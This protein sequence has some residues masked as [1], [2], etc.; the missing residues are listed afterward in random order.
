M[1]DYKGP[2]LEAATTHFD[3][4]H[5]IEDP[6]TRSLMESTYSFFNAAKRYKNIGAIHKRGIMLYGPPGTGKSSILNIV[7]AKI[8]ES[9]GIVLFAKQNH[10]RSVETLIHQIRNSQ[11][12]LWIGVV[13]E[14]IETYMSNNLNLKMMLSLLSGESQVG[15]VIYMATTN[16][17]IS[18]LPEAITKRP[19]RFDVVLKVDFPS[20]ES[21]L[22]FL[23]K[24]VKGNLSETVCK[25]IAE[26]T[27]GLS[28]AHLKEIVVSHYCLQEDLQ[29][30]I[31]RVSSMRVTAEPVLEDHD[32]DSLESE[33]E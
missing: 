9:G 21:K 4:V 23:T 14:D 17:D 5:D 15:G 30:T 11:P 16:L 32:F 25:K 18:E 3:E 24:L 13:M 27:E 6:A 19:S 20:V 10:I 31:K 29:K 8:I 33:E 26:S 2:F 28:I 1:A 12:D 22:R 7:T